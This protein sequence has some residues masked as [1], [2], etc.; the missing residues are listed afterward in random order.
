M[1]D[2]STTTQATQAFAV[3]DKQEMMCKQIA[4][5]KQSKSL[6]EF[7]VEVTGQKAILA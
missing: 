6:L 5:K 7:K 1:L 2:I 4:C 3:V